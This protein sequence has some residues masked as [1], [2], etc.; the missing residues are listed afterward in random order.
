M[1]LNAEHVYRVWDTFA[2]TGKGIVLQSM[3]SMIAEV[4]PPFSAFMHMMK[5]YLRTPRK[6]VGFEA[7]MAFAREMGIYIHY[8]AH[9][10]WTSGK[11]GEAG[12]TLQGVAAHGWSLWRSELSMCD[13]DSA[14]TPDLLLVKDITG[15]VSTPPPR[16]RPMRTRVIRAART[17]PVCAPAHR[18]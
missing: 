13:D 18:T 15:A 2:Q 16:G 9:C 3:S 5:G 12:V 4:L 6:W 10:W 8:K 1:R 14:G 11:V 17:V 7:R